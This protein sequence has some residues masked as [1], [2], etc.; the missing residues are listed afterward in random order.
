[1]AYL[2][3][4]RWKLPTLAHQAERGAPG[5]GV[6]SLIASACR[7]CGHYNFPPRA[8]CRYCG[9][10][11]LRTVVLPVDVEPHPGTWLFGA[12]AACDKPN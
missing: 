6:D 8:Y 1:M 9:S 7:D 3:I 2:T 10:L 4:Q 11:R 5:E 12:A